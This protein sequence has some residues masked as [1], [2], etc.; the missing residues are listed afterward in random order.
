MWN[1][2]GL[3]ANWPNKN[4]S[5]DHP[6]SY[7][8]QRTADISQLPTGIRILCHLSFTAQPCGQVQ[9]ATA[10]ARESKSSHR[11]SENQH[12]EY[13]KLGAR[14]EREHSPPLV[15]APQLVNVNCRL[16]DV[17]W[18]W[19]NGRQFTFTN[20]ILLLWKFRNV[21][22]L[23]QFLLFSLPILMR[24]PPIIPGRKRHYESVCIGDPG[25]ARPAS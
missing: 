8:P 6:V 25:P 12:G 4:F 20:W 1:G 11:E 24:I 15:K 7:I 3:T 18:T 22:D 19:S 16:S 13:K 21:P 5:A 17:E 14:L 2:L 23:P 9:M 10:E